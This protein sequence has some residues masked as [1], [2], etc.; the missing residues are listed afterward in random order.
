MASNAA[1]HVCAACVPGQRNL[2]GKMAAN[3]C[4]SERFVKLHRWDRTAIGFVGYQSSAHDRLGC[5]GPAHPIPHRPPPPKLLYGRN[6]TESEAEQMAPPSS[7]PCTT[8]IGLSNCAV[9]RTPQPISST[10]QS[11]HLDTEDNSGSATLLPLLNIY[12]GCLYAYTPEVLP[13]AHRGTGNGIA[14]GLNR[15][16]GIMSAIVATFADTNTPVPIYI[17][18]ALYIVM[19]IVAACFPFEPMGKRS[20]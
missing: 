11:R 3:V 12:Y 4:L 10:R 19:A 20:S 14:I 6:P 13:S 9:H 5:V 15:V 16:M 17:C 18:A 1:S 7:T 2:V 8:T